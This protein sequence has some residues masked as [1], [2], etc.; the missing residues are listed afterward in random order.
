VETP[1]ITSIEHFM[2]CLHIVN[3]ED[4]S[5]VC[6][7]CR[8]F[9]LRRYLTCFYDVLYFVSTLKLSAEFKFNFP[10]FRIIFGPEVEKITSGRINMRNEKF[11]N[12]YSSRSINGMNISRG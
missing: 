9:Y 4:R 10:S 2:C 3:T 1:D 5:H 6:L 12:L 8:I 11:H 7:S